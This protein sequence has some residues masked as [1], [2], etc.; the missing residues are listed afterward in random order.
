MKL[1][2]SIVNRILRWLGIIFLA[3]VLLLYIGLP[4]GLGVAAIIPGKTPPGPPPAG[5]EAVTLQTGDGVPLAGCYAPPQGTTAIILMH[6]AGS[7]RE[8]L[9][10]Y[11]EMLTRNGYGVLAL[12]M[13]GHG[14]SGGPTNRLGWQGTE[15]VAAAVAFLEARPEVQHIGGLGLSLG[16]EVLLG[17]AARL[18]MLEVI[19]ADG[20]SRRSLPELLSLSSERPLVRNFTARVMYATVQLLSGQQPPLPML[21]SMTQA[22]TTEFL[23]VAAGEDDLEVKFNRLFADTL[24]ERA[25]LWIALGASHTG[26]FGLY[27]DVYEQRVLDFFGS[28]L[29]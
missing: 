7:S 20:A 18:P 26:A 13:R 11:A 3:L 19:V 9:R 15:D 14:A 10:P 24:G 28:S 23:L 2:K 22:S 29:K 25:Q 5:F 12:D 4:V 6:G 17:A 21:E 8:S 1:N 16:G 27:P